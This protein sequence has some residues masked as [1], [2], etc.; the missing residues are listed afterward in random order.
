M[1]LDLDLKWIWFALAAM[2]AL[3]MLTSS[4]GY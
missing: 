4:V 2:F 1:N 3:G